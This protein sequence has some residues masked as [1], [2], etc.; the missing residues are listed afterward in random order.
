MQEVQGFLK[1]L[2]EVYGVF[3]LDYSL[4]LSTRPESYLGEIEFWNKAEAALTS[5]LDSTGL[6]WTIKEGE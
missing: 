1:L 3:G 4:A 2:S 5:A 6:A